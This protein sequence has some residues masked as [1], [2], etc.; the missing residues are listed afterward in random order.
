MSADYRLKDPET[1]K[2]IGMA[3][4]VHNKLGC[5]FLEAVY[6][7]ALE[8]EFK[9]NDIQ[10]QREKKLP[11]YYSGQLLKTSYRVDFICYNSTIV[12]L[13]AIQKL[14]NIEYAQVINYLKSSGLMK[15]LLINFGNTKLQYKR[16]VLNHND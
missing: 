1:H 12:E 15:S 11:I 2:I 5:G 10:Y 13:K 7:E 8:L 6:H 9:K 3:M 4:A 14:T 16:L